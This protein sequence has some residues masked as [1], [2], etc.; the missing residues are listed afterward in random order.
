MPEVLSPNAPAATDSPADI[1]DDILYEVIDG[2]IVE[3]PPMGAFENWIMSWLVRSLNSSQSVCG[4]GMVVP[5][6]LFLIDPARN[7]KRRPDL[8]FVSFERWPADRPV[9]IEEAWDVVPDLVI[10]IVSK[11]NKASEVVRKILDY[12]GAGARQVWV[13]YPIEKM[14]YVH[15]SRTE[16]VVLEPGQ[17]LDGGDVLP[18][19]RLPVADL[20]KIKVE[21]APPPAVG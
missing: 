10:E 17:D 11:S 1:D 19:F 13:V 8:A 14:I 6:M 12:F 3:K 18:G 4:I 2:R 21:S 9:P 15:R 5:E 16:I 20:L 7:L